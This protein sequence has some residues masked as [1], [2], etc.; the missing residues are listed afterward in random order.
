MITPQKK[1][2]GTI[3]HSQALCCILQVV[4]CVL[5]PS[6][7]WDVTGSSSKELWHVHCTNRR[8]INIAAYGLWVRSRLLSEAG[9]W[10]KC[11]GCAVSFRYEASEIRAGMVVL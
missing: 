6:K 10:S 2:K 9:W 7:C 11:K 1:A 4:V 8:R 3:L 5:R